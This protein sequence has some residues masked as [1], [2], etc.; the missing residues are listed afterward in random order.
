MAIKAEPGAQ[1]QSALPPASPYAVVTGAG[2]Y[3]GGREPGAAHA[4]VTVHGHW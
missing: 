3:Q 1:V 4:E 2:R